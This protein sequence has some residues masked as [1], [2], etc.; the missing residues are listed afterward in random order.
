[1]LLPPTF[2]FIK[3]NWLSISGSWN[4]ADNNNGYYC[5][6][7]CSNDFLAA[8]FILDLYGVYPRDGKY[9]MKI[10]TDIEKISKDFE[11]SNVY[12][13]DTFDHTF[14]VIYSDDEHIYYV[15]YRSG[16]FRFELITRECLI[17][18]FDSYLGEDFKF[19]AD[20]HRKSESYIVKE[21]NEAKQLSNGKI[22]HHQI[23]YAKYP[24]TF[25]PTVQTILSV[26]KESLHEYIVDE[27]YVNIE[28]WKS[29]RSVFID[30]LE[31]LVKVF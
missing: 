30:N 25:E 27:N 31:T 4:D 18:Y 2:Q 12:M 28:D 14:A 19:Y 3:N 17:Q 24:I 16:K 22:N 20:F 10:A 15:D 29:I 8:G 11:A 13:I 6:S 7:E 5:G 23:K 9:G 21:Y 26:I 1:M